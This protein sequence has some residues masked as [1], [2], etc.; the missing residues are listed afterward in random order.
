MI[1][2]RISPT[3]PSWIRDHLQRYIETNGEDGHIWDATMAGGK[4]SYP[5]LLL[6]TVG[7]K[8][9]DPITLPLIYG[10][11]GNKYVIAASR[12][13]SPE[14]PAWYLN[15]AANPAVGVQVKGDRF[16]ARARTATG[17]ERAE[18]WKLMISIYAP[19]AEY[20][21]NAGK[22]EI[23]VVVLERA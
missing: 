18:L 19:Y 14:H 17:A 22:R 11:S 3:L 2:P 8:S 9:G 6:T 5:T 16:D 15:L 1:E 21:V 4:G 23:P 10:K 7:R 12:G 13:G 20:Q